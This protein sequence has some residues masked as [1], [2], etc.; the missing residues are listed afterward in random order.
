MNTQLKRKDLL[1]YGLMAL[2]LAFA[3]LPIYLHAPDFYAG[4][5]GQS[6]TSLGLLLL[7]L[8]AVDAIQDPL[9]GSLSDRYHQHRALILVLGVMMLGGGF[10]MLFHPY[11]SAPLTWFAVA[12][13]ICTTGFSIVSIN[14]QTL[15]G[16]WQV[17]EH[18]RTRITSWREALGLL[19]LLTAA[20]GPALLGANSDA[21]TAFHRLTI[22]Y[23]PLLAVATWALLAWMKTAPLTRPQEAFKPSGETRGSWRALISNPWRSRFF[24]LFALNTLAS[25]IPAV[26]VLFFIRDRLGAAE[27]SGL[28]L[29][30]Y[31]LFGAL[32]MPLWQWLSKRVGKIQAWAVSMALSIITFLWAIF[33]QD[34]QV[35]AYALVCALSGLALGADLALPPSILADHIVAEKSQAEASRMFSLMTLLSKASLALA[36]GLALPLLG[37]AGYQPGIAMTTELNLTLSLSYAALPCILK[38]ITLVWLLSQANHIAQATSLKA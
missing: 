9:I 12:V 1:S 24:A 7:A 22:A 14:L 33:L 4:T 32:A 16:I 28:F 10:W 15:G 20:M 21:S 6:L 19:G 30:V 3:G 18:Q 5:L 29:L 8:R 25:A 17:S 38:T 13:F 27:Y 35:E 34:G 23:L 2:P 36:T 31:F 11:L 37:L 26:L